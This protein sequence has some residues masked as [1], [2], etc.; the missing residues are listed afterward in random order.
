LRGWGIL[1]RKE[2]KRRKGENGVQGNRGR[3]KGLG[4][5]EEQN[6]GWIKK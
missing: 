6:G 3:G 5:M 1:N 4:G 2:K